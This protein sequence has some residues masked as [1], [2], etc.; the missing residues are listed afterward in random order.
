MEQRHHFELAEEYFGYLAWR[1]P[2]MCASDEFHFLPRAEEAATY[3]HKLDWLSPESIEEDISVLKDFQNR[4]RQLSSVQEDPEIL[5][6]LRLLIANAAGFLMELEVN[7]TWRHNPLLYLKIGFIGLDH[8]LTKPAV[9]STEKFDRTLSRLGDIPRLIDQGINNIQGIPESYHQA[10]IGMIE[11]CRAYLIEEV[12]DLFGIGSDRFQ[13]N[14]SLAIRSLDRFNK[15][16]KSSRPVSDK[17]FEAASIETTLRDHFLY[18][19]PLK[20]IF[21][22]AVEEWERNLKELEKLRQEIDNHSS[23]QDLY[24]AYTP[25]GLDTHD[26]FSLY[27]DEIRNM[28]HFFQEK[29]LCVT[30]FLQTME[31][32]ETPRYLRSVRS[33]ASF[34]ASLTASKLEKSYFYITTESKGEEFDVLRKKRFHR[35]YRFLTAH[36][37]VPGHHFLDSIR[38]ELENPVRRQ[39][40]SALFYEG[41]ASFSESLLFEYGYLRNPLDRLV[42]CKRWLWRAARCQIDVGIPQ[43]LLTADAAVELLLNAGFSKV[44]AI[45][46]IDRFSLNPGYQLCYSLGGYEFKQI[47]KNYGNRLDKNVFYRYLLGGGELPFSIIRERFDNLLMRQ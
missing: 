36:E 28:C 19:R 41:W 6:D 10:A 39:I 13:S 33:G 43:G 17:R 45:K 25:E 7:Q 2:V 5:I 47:K 20:E 8:A 38:R 11:D 3:I 23:W 34:G 42:N 40:E 46:Q 4:F 15:F 32:K 37:T 21:Y 44:E 29:G 27:G 24:H 31:L 14:F 26:T 1:Y 30:D 35:E 18:F 9:D 12:S 22:I 16:L